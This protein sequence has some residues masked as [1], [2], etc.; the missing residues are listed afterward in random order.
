MHNRKDM[1]APDD[2]LIHDA[3]AAVEAPARPK[4][5]RRAKETTGLVRQRQLHKANEMIAMRPKKGRLTLLSWK[6]YN[7]LLY[8]SQQ[9]HADRLRKN[10]DA[11]GLGSFSMHLADLLAD[12]HYDSKSVGLFKEH[13]RE[14]QTTLIEWN[15]NSASERHWASS[16]LLGGVEIHERG[17]PYPT[18]LSWNYPER[19]REH[20]LE[21]KRYTKLML[22]IGDQIRTLAAAV[23]LDVGLRYLTSPSGLSLREEVH[24]WATAL[25]GRSDIAEV[26]YRY[27]KRDVVRPALAEIENLQNEFSLELIEHREGRRVVEL[28]FQVRRKVQANLGVTEPK[29]VFDLALLDRIHALGVRAQDADTLYAQTDEALL[30]VTVEAVEERMKNRKLKPLD[31]PAA[32]FRDALRKGYAA[33]PSHAGDTPVEE[34]SVPVPLPVERRAPEIARSQ[35][36]VR[37]DWVRALAKEAERRFATLDPAL[38]QD[39][40]QRFDEQEVPKMMDAIA[41]AWRAEGVGSRSAK[42]TFFKW[43]A[44]APPNVDPDASQLLEFT[45]AGNKLPPHAFKFPA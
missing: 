7:A 42:H 20:V 32:F 19:V 33:L 35:Q 5:T 4:V 28:Q 3:P 23:L 2:H 25:T 16:Q 37:D 15:S 30:R 43:I 9:Q 44:T 17:A 31:S 38:K 21:P 1:T 26:D 11:P 14:M 39:L 45:L 34:P 12:A 22:E 13:I 8:H 6:I 29:N 36:T 41:R 18:T 40:L 10:P 27:F 24:W